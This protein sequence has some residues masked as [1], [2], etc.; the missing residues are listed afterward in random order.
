MNRRHNQAVS[1]HWRLVRAGSLD[2]DGT[3]VIFNTGTGLKYF[4]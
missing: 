4:V 3:I 2:P 1:Y